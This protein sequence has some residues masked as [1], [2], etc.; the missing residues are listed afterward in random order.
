MSL[1]FNDSLV[2]SS[3]APFGINLYTLSKE[4]IKEKTC[5]QVWPITDRLIGSRSLLSGKKVNFIRSFG[6]QIGDRQKIENA[7]CHW[8]RT[9]VDGQTLVDV[10]QM[11]GRSF[12]CQLRL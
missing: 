6:S 11:I 9:S 8:A 4:F 12:S 1:G 5:V 3:K 2:K 7:P 10:R